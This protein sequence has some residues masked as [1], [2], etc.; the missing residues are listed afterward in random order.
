MQ[1]VEVKVKTSPHGN[2]KFI[3]FDL[4]WILYAIPTAYKTLHI[5]KGTFNSRSMKHWTADE[6]VQ[7]I[8][9]T[10]DVKLILKNGDEI[11]VEG[12]WFQYITRAAGHSAYNPK[13]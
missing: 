3:S 5:E 11:V 13:Y 2:N 9:K 1:L 8:D 7:V 10:K 4:Q 12:E 6:D